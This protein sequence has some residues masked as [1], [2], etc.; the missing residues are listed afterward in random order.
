MTPKKVTLTNRWIKW[1]Q[2][3]KWGYTAWACMMLAFASLGVHLL[4]FLP[5]MVR[6]IA[7]ITMISFASLCELILILKKQWWWATYWGICVL[8]GVGAWEIMSYFFGSQL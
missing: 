8:L 3:D 1:E 5:G 4:A 6:G 2:V 7:L